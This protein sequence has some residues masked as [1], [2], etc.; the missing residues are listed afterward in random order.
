MTKEEMQADIDFLV[1]RQMKCGSISFGSGRDTGISSN[2]LVAMAYGVGSQAMP[3]D[4]G[5]YSACVRAVRRLPRHR[6]TPAIL[7]ALAAAK[8]AVVA[9]YPTRRAA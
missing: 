2:S 1:R 3:S 8:A 9:K 6:R 7:T 4:W 5:D